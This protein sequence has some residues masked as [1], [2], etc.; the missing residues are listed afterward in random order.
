[1]KKILLF[2]FVISLLSLSESCKK[3]ECP[4]Y[5]PS[6]EELIIQTEWNYYKVEEK[7]QNGNV[8]NTVAVNYDMVFEVSGHYYS[9][10]SSGSLA[11]GGTWEL[12]DDKTIKIDSDN[13]TIDTITEDEFIMIFPDTNSDHW[14]YMR[15][16]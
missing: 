3:E 9:Y 6:V 15:K 8:L 14:V 12:I 16:K 4:V 5:K 10:D 11:F 7:D 1:M 13:A 2:V